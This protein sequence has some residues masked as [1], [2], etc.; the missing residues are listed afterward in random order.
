MC[1]AGTLD[2]II[3]LKSSAHLE[4]CDFPQDVNQNKLVSIWRDVLYL[5]TSENPLH[6]KK[7]QGK[8]QTP[9]SHAK[10]LFDKQSFFIN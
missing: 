8:H 6:M 1:G 3:S 2:C 9:A 4:N 7:E 10:L 5:T